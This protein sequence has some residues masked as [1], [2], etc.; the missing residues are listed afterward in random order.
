MTG[1][2]KSSGIQFDAETAQRIERVDETSDAARR[3]RAVL[4][5]LELAPGERVIDIGTG[6]GFVAREACEIVGSG[7]R[8]L[9][10]DTSEPMLDLARRRC[11]SWPYA[12]FQSG[13]ATQLPAEDGSFDAAVSVQV[14]EY[15]AN[16]EMALAEMHRVL[17]PGGR[18]VVM[19]TDCA[20]RASCC[21]I[22][23]SSRNST[24]DATRIPTAII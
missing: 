5:A 2:P 1:K 7:G 8:V 19:S 24:R 9:G 14:F 20:G 6:P 17:R 21:K 4:A 11:S 13:N 15:V 23:G 3:R 22:R 12:E 16:V 10:V 18:A